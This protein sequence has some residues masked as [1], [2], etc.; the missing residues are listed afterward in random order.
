MPGLE[1]LW[2]GSGEALVEYTGV[3]FVLWRGILEVGG[4]GLEKLWLSILGCTGSGEV[5]C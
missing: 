5:F 4:V 3:S 2:G 1:S